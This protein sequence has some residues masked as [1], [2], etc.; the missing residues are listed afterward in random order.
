[1][2]KRDEE[3]FI[4]NCGHCETHAVYKR[5]NS[6]IERG[7]QINLTNLSESTSFSLKPNNSSFSIVGRLVYT[8]NGN[9]LFLQDNILNQSSLPRFL[10]IPCEISGKFKSNIMLKCCETE[11]SFVSCWLIIRDWAI[12][13]M[14]TKDP[15][16]PLRS[17]LL[18]RHLNP[19]NSQNEITSVV[20]IL[21]KKLLCFSAS[22]TLWISSSY[23]PVEQMITGLRS[24]NITG[25]VIHISTVVMH[26]VDNYTT[27]RDRVTNDEKSMINRAKKNDSEELDSNSHSIF[28]IDKILRP[29]EN[30]TCESSFSVVIRSILN[31][32]EFIVF[33]PGVNLLINRFILGWRN[34]YRFEN[35]VAGSVLIHNFRQLPKEKRCLIANNFTSIISESMVENISRPILEIPTLIQIEKVLGF[36]VYEIKTKL[37]PIKLFLHNSNF[38]ETSLGCSISKGS[39][40]WVRN[41]RVIT[42]KLGNRSFP[43]GIAIEPGS[44]W[45]LE[46]HSRFTK[47]KETTPR[48]TIWNNLPLHIQTIGHEYLEFNDFNSNTHTNKE[49]AWQHPWDIRNFCYLH[50]SL[51]VD[52]F[53]IV[54]TQT[55][56]SQVL[57]I[58]LVQ[59]ISNLKSGSPISVSKNY[60]IKY[61]DGTKTSKESSSII[62]GNFSHFQFKITHPS[63]TIE[64]K[65]RN[66]QQCPVS[67]TEECFGLWKIAPIEEWA[68]LIGSIERSQKLNLANLVFLNHVLSIEFLYYIRGNIKKL[69]RLR[70]VEN[71]YKNS[72]VSSNI[73]SLKCLFIGEESYPL[74]IGFFGHFLAEIIMEKTLESNI[75]ISNVCFIKTPSLSGSESNFYPLFIYC[76]SRINLLFNSSCSKY[77]FEKKFVFIKKAMLRLYNQKISFFVH[78]SDIVCINFE[79]CFLKP[80]ISKGLISI[81]Q[82]KGVL[83]FICDKEIENSVDGYK[84][85]FHCLPFFK[86]YSKLSKS[87]VQLDKNKIIES[88]IEK[89]QV[90]SNWYSFNNISRF[91]LI[92]DTPILPNSEVLLSIIQEKEFF[93]AMNTFQSEKIEHLMIKEL[94]FPSQLSSDAINFDKTASYIEIKL[95]GDD[96]ESILWPES[97]KTPFSFKSG[98]KKQGTPGLYT[99]FDIKYWTEYIY[100]WQV[101]SRKN[102]LIYRSTKLARNDMVDLFNNSYPKLSFGDESDSEIHIS[103][104]RVKI[105]DIIYFIGLNPQNIYG[106]WSIIRVTTDQSTKFKPEKTTFQSIYLI[107]DPPW[108]SGWIDIW[109]SEEET[110]KHNIKLLLPGETVS[111][112]N[113]KVEKF[114]NSSFPL[115][116]VSNIMSTIL[117][118]FCEFP[119]KD[120]LIYYSKRNRSQTTSKKKPTFSDSDQ[121]QNE[122]SKTSNTLSIFNNGVIIFKVSIQNSIIKSSQTQIYSLNEHPNNSQ[123]NLLFS[124]LY[125]SPTSISEVVSYYYF[126]PG[127]EEYLQKSQRKTFDSYNDHY[128]SLYETLEGEIQFNHQKEESSKFF[129]SLPSF[130][131]STNSHQTFNPHTIPNPYVLAPDG[132]PI[133]H[134]FLYLSRNNHASFIA[135]NKAYCIKTEI[136][137]KSPQEDST[138]SSNPFLILDLFRNIDPDLVFSLKGSILHIQ[139][140]DL[141]WFCLNCLQNIMGKLVCVCGVDLGKSSFW[142]SLTIYLIGALELETTDSKPKLFP[143]VMTN[144]NVIKLLAYVNKID[145]QEQD[146]KILYNH[147]IELAKIIWNHMESLNDS[148]GI[149][150]LYSFG[151]VPA[152]CNF[153]NSMEDNSK[154]CRPVGIIGQVELFDKEKAVNIP[155]DPISNLEMEACLRCAQS[156][157]RNTLA[158]TYLHVIRWKTRNTKL[159]L[160]EKLKNINSVC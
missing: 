64:L 51:Y 150:T 45:G 1:M 103:L 43:I 28:G 140:I 131:Y 39:I 152:D 62:C 104:E 72:S 23:L 40:L 77:S 25:L 100:E 92:I 33:F 128:L 2:K 53:N 141:S 158:Y 159:E 14:K 48:E 59:I 91:V 130:Q 135:F 112:S 88:Q 12:V 7:E 57:P 93:E 37:V 121:A 21:K 89:F 47:K 66:L 155:T 102:P 9:F 55:N 113:I 85:Y 32:R 22:T 6:I 106:N 80:P 82:P 4:P 144:W 153:L 31:N 114:I 46:R 110:L 90:P 160:E 146:S 118:E 79:D 68:D 81:N 139:Q 95:F 38:H 124:Y 49:I 111:F 126:D 133:T 67:C 86:T 13:K 54:G 122:K 132:A 108:N 18:N 96:D 60:E 10:L 69:P 8:K 74:Y 156:S 157:D 151:E 127:Y 26:R 42:T 142:K 63:Q 117:N 99:V 84:L 70:T 115:S 75:W 129:H 143:F 19:F 120:K 15:N 30:S 17:I 50:Y 71:N 125:F 83:L 94:V 134:S 154:E 56:K 137:T 24:I 148:S 58:L 52:L 145:N 149:Q 116:P 97:L 123:E 29:S 98:S 20:K 87:E 76:N 34:I 138:L 136:S 65:S 36:G 109:F 35:V 119:K 41:F 27:S 5:I 101:F 3:N 105:L 147:I 73:N 44:D 16:A 11:F 61:S 78:I 107:S